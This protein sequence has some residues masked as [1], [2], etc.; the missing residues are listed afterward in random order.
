MKMVKLVPYNDEKIGAWRD[1]P[2]AC[3][4]LKTRLFF[5][6]LFQQKQGVVAHGFPFFEQVWQGAVGHINQ[7]HPMILVKAR[8]WCTVAAHEGQ[9]P[10]G[11]YTFGID[12]V[13][14]QLFNCPFAF[15]VGVIALLGGEFSKHLLR[16]FEALFEQAFGGTPRRY[17]AHVGFIKWRVLVLFRSFYHCSYFLGQGTA[18]FKYGAP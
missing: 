13:L 1:L 12:Q 5:G 2:V 4:A 6:A 14:N 9:G 10:V 15:G 8:E 11:K 7:F 17:T 18:V 16:C 3:N